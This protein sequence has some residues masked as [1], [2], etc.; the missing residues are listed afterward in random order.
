M[1]K[2]K[3]EVQSDALISNVVISHQLLSASVEMFFI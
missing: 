2:K 1:E 3:V